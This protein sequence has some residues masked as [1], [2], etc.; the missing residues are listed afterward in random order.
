M[1]Q[2]LKGYFINIE[3]LESDYLSILHRQILEH[4]RQHKIGA[5]TSFVGIVRASSDTETKKVIAMDVEIWEEKGNQMINE[6]A[7]DIL[8]KFG[9]LDIRIVHV[10]GNL[11]LGDP[12]VYVVLAS[13]HRKE[14]FDALAASIDAYKNDAPVWKKEIYEDGSSSWIRTAKLE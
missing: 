10:Y 2:P 4:N 8:E 11:K 13:E 9:L 7:Y 5:I 12:I 1:D 6:I 14:G 3:A